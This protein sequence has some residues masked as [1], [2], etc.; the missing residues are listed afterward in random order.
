MRLYPPKPKVRLRVDAPNDAWHV[1]RTLIKLLDGTRAYLSCI[2]DNY[3]RRIL[4]WH[5]ADNALSFSTRIVLL[6]AA[7]LIKNRDRQVKVLVDDGSENKGSI[8][9]PVFDDLPVLKRIVAQIQIS[10]SNSMI[11][12][13]F[14]RLKHGWL[15][16]NDLRDFATLEKLI[17]FYVQEHK[18][19]S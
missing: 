9:D 7:K 14:S 3:S 2:I 15:Y 18:Y 10:F 11:E 5:L 8:V 16:L 6:E 4:A 12:A 1:D 17:S 13:F 19:A